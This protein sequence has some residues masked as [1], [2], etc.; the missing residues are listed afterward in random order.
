MKAFI[1]QIVIIQIIALC[2][3]GKWYVRPIADFL[4]LVKNQEYPISNL[5]LEILKRY[6]YNYK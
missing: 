5:K 3:E 6:K 2:A 4:I 1:G